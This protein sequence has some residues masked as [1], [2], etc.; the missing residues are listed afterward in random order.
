MYD[1][2]THVARKKAPKMNGRSRAIAKRMDP[3][4][5]LSPPCSV[6]GSEGLALR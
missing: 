1:I 3:T 6:L 2:P 4:F 5:P